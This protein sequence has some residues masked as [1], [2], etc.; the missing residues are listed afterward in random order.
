MAAPMPDVP[1]QIF[2]RARERGETAPGT[3]LDLILI[4]DQ[5]YGV[6]WYRILAGHDAPLGDA[7][8]V[9]Q[10]GALAAQARGGGSGPV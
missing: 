8:A 5:A 6:L 3:D 1:P 10:A 7:Q 9:D 2:E 4:V